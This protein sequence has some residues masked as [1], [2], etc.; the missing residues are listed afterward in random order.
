MDEGKTGA[1][2]NLASAA[3]ALLAAAGIAVTIAVC[4]YALNAQ[5]VIM[6]DSSNPAE[7][8]EEFLTLVLSGNSA[9]AETMLL[10]SGKLGLAT[11]GETELSRMLFN[12]L[13]ESFSYEKLGSCDKHGL[14]AQQ[15]FT[16]TYLDIP[17]LTALQREAT[18]ARLARYLDEAERYDDVLTED[19]AFRTDVAMRALAE[20]TA[21]LLEN[22]QEYY[23]QTELTINMQYSGGEWKIAA[24]DTLATILSGGTAG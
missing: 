1:V 13:H 23:V 17:S 20:V 24:N 9:E 10:G 2:R 14:E 18:N 12:A 21:E 15:S 11:E 7:C 4:T 8:A 3:L 5:P 22:A 6:D 19:G 16:V